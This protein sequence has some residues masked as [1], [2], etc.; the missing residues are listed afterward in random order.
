MFLI[1]IAKIDEDTGVARVS[2]EL[3]GTKRCDQESSNAAR[4]RLIEDDFAAIA[5]LLQ[6]KEEK[7][8]DIDI[9]QSPTYGIRSRY[10]RTSFIFT[11]DVKSM[12]DL[13]V[14][15]VNSSKR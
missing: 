12:S 6:I 7:Y 14:V 10:M 13:H 4:R 8:E 15:P 11:L 2:C 3:P 9:R 5:D 1:K